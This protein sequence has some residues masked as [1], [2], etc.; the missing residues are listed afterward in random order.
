MTTGSAPA[1]VSERRQYSPGDLIGNKYL[2]DHVIGSG[3]MGTVWAATNLDLDLAV[4]LKVVNPGADREE[5]AA[6]LSMEARAEAKLQHPGI[7]RVIDLGITDNGEPFLVMELLEGESLAE[8]V[9]RVGRLDACAAVRMILPVVDALRY[10]HS[11]N[12]IHR[13]LKPDNIFLSRQAGHVQPKIVDFGIAKLGEGTVCRTRTGTGTVVGSP[14]YMAPEHARGK[15][16]DHRA[17]IFTVCLVLY[18]CITGTA[19]FD[20]DSYNALLRAVIE[21]ELPPITWFGFGDAKLSAIITRGL[22]KDPAKRFASCDE[23]GRALAAWLVANGETEDVTGAP[24]RGRWLARAPRTSE[25]GKTPSSPLPAAGRSRPGAGSEHSVAFPT[26]ALPMRHLIGGKVAFAA[27]VLGGFL[28]G[29]GATTSVDGSGWNLFSKKPSPAAAGADVSSAPAASA[30]A[31]EGQPVVRP[32]EAPPAV[33]A[34]PRS[35][36]MTRAVARNVVAARR[37]PVAAATPYPQPQ[38]PVF[39]LPS[40]PALASVANVANV[41]TAANR[42]EL[43]DPYQ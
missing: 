36:E 1:A 18:E 26:A 5:I 13:D 35:P 24:L 30:P 28:V 33:P 34:A 10:A 20:G 11:R 32:V 9:E 16:V 27:L 21:Q 29:F 17:D 37:K 12:V 3:G 2:L 8:L 14:G 43:K 6:R 23:L 40:Q 25:S 31:R 19:A 42:A 22:A 7:V 15:E 41:A 4:A 39:E 38:V